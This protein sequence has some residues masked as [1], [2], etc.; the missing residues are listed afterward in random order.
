VTRRALAA[1]GAA[2]AE[3]PASAV[4]RLL[5]DRLDQSSVLVCVG[6]ARDNARQ[7][8]EQI[9]TEMWERMNRLFLRLR[10]DGGAVAAA[11]PRNRVIEELHQ[12]LGAIDATMSHGEGWRFLQAGRHLERFQ[13][14]Q[15][16][17][18]AHLDVEPDDKYGF[19][20]LLRM[21][22]ALEPFLRARTADMR[23]DRV[24]GFL[25][26]D[27]EFPRSLRHCATALRAHVACMGP[28]APPARREPVER[29]MGRL[30][31]RLAFAHPSE[32]MGTGGAAF[33]AGLAVEANAI[34][35]LVHDSFVDYGVVD[36]V[37][38]GVG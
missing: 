19:A 5:H 34:H 12:I 21:A 13:L 1:L 32:V 37:P 10:A 17:I 8:R 11:P 4:E 2:P 36:P 15:R 7:I 28:F 27:P 9:S 3:N 16:L 38:V 31:A 24:I 30:E 35:A 26:L 22:C 18:A 23:R 29:A 14:M 6:H 25:A 20:Q 33:L